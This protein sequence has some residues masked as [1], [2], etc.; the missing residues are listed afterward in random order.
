VNP[1]HAPIDPPE[2]VTPTEPDAVAAAPAPQ[3]T[4]EDVIA[5]AA[6]V[7][8]SLWAALEPIARAALAS[9]AV[10]WRQ[11]NAAHDADREHFHALLATAPGHPARAT[12]PLCSVPLWKV[13][14]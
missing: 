8:K 7:V 10:L 5:A 3:P 9:F 4:L 11:L 14:P 2:L 13:K 1:D 12:C 6:D